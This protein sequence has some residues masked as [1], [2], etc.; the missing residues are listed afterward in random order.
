[1]P[2]SLSPTSILCRFCSRVLHLFFLTPA[3]RVLLGR[4]S[5]PS[6]PDR[7]DAPG[8]G[9]ACHP[10]GDAGA[11]SA[12]FPVPATESLHPVPRVA[13]P[14]PPTKPRHLPLPTTTPVIAG[15][16]ALHTHARSDRYLAMTRPS[17]VRASCNAVVGAK[18]RKSDIG[19]HAG[20]RSKPPR[21]DSHTS[22][23]DPGV[24]LTVAR[25][26]PALSARWPFRVGW[27][28][29]CSAGIVL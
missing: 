24:S 16:L 18:S 9:S 5:M 21:G 29:I 7:P 25:L 1:M 14:Y 13:A 8:S 27:I 12:A 19:S 2:L 4:S 15:P 11:P 28:H 6:S 17:D 22:R 20:P 23:R 26:D 10:C 3:P